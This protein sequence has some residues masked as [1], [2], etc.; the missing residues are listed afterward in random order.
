LAK[1]AAS[2][3]ES[4]AAAGDPQ[5]QF[6]L[7][8][9]LLGGETASTDGPRAIA[10]ID[11]AAAAGHGPAIEMAA[12]FEA[13]GAARPQNWLRSIELL[14]RAA[15]LGSTSAK[16]QIDALRPRGLKPEEFL[17]VPQREVLSNSPRLIVFRDFATPSECDWAIARANGRLTRAAVFNPETGKQMWNPVRDN[18]GSEFQ[19]PEMDVVLEVLRARISAATR[20][21]VPIFEPV[22][23]LHYAVG[24]QFRP[25]HDF[26]DPNVPEFAQEISLHGQRIGTMLV[27]LN[28]GYEGGETI[29]PKLG[30]S[31]KGSRGD[32]L[33]FTNVDRNGQPD[34]MTTH[35][36]TPPTAGEKWVISQWIRDRAPA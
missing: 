21:P 2:D 34:P 36:G 4:S 19:L 31:F 5:A 14:S 8:R 29:F 24:Q 35:A 10:L 1:S 23:V 9:A 22:Q 33:F 13:M 28:E 12:L 17:E 3:L 30:L 18:S 32:A 20:L 7:G 26:L 25:H 15:E 16:G 6:E 27:Y 11:E